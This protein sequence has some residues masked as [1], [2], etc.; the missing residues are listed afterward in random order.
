[1]ARVVKLGTRRFKS[2]RFQCS[3]TLALSSISA[4][5]DKAP[6]LVQGWHQSLQDEKLVLYLAAFVQERDYLVTLLCL[7]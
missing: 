7:L 5:D 4:F 3:D 1:M 2:Y 6:D